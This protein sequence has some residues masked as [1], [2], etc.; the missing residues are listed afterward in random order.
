MAESELVFS[1]YG[2]VRT[3]S[4]GVLL[5]TRLS[6]LTPELP[7]AKSAEAIESPLSQTILTTSYLVE[8]HE[9]GA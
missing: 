7:I 9:H 1:M 2:R 6:M 8:E 5:M 4:I 3:V